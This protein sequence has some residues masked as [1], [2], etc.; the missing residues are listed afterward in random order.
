MQT[1][2]ERQPRNPPGVG[3]AVRWPM[4]GCE[5]SRLDA[6]SRRAA[7]VRRYFLGMSHVRG[8]RLGEGDA[9]A[10][11]SFPAAHARLHR[12]PHRPVPTWVIPATCGV[13]RAPRGDPRW[14]LRYFVPSYALEMSDAH[15][16]EHALRDTFSACVQWRNVYGV[17]FLPNAPRSRRALLQKFLG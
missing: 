2:F 13:P 4:C 5:H 14:R 1:G 9:R 10:S 11:E 6:C 7:A 16:C 12:P 8:I 17:Q 3:A 15:H